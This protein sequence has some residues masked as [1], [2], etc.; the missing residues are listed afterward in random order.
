MLGDILDITENGGGGG[1]ALDGGGEGIE[2]GDSTVAVAAVDA[3]M[4]AKFQ[5][6]CDVMMLQP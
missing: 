6:D 3:L 5:P 4:V 2:A 1:G